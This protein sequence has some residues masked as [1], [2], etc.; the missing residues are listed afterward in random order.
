MNNKRTLFYFCPFTLFF[1]PW[2]RLGERRDKNIVS[3]L[4]ATM[5][6]GKK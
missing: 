1:T 6:C 5:F 3:V 2:D 4:K